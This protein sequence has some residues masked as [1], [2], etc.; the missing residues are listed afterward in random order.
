MITSCSFGS[1]SFV[2][3][4]IS[5]SESVEISMTRVPSSMA[6]GYAVTQLLQGASQGVDKLPESIAIP[7]PGFLQ[8]KSGLANSVHV[9]PDM[10]YSYLKN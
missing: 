3:R 7:D 9:P 6:S 5:I 8:L 10:L 2:V 4:S 1:S